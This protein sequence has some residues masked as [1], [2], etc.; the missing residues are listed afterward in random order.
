M[1]V[2]E[3]LEA[4]SF[5]DQAIVDQAIVDHGFTRHTATTAWSPRSAAN[6]IRASG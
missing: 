4:Y 2:R 1:S 5:F 3:T 6:R